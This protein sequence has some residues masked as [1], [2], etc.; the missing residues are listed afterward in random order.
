VNPSSGTVSVTNGSLVGTD[1]ISSTASLTSPAIVT[2]NVGNYSLTPSGVTFATGNASNYM[3]SYVN[4]TL[5]IMPRAITVKANNASRVYGDGNPASGA[6]SVIAGGLV[7]TDALGDANLLSAASAASSVGNYSL[8]PSGVKFTSGSAANYVIAYADGIL[9][10]TPRPL[11]VE[12]VGK[13]K[14]YDGTTSASVTF[15]DNRLD[16]DNFT[17]N[18]NAA[19]SDPDP[20]DNKTVSVTNINISGAD[21]GNYSLQN[22]F[23]FTTADIV[24]R[25]SALNKARSYLQPLFQPLMV[26]SAVKVSFMDTPNSDYYDWLLKNHL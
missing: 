24:T 4:G 14:L 25:E 3:I 5:T 6:V 23:A 16:G 1:A 11:S 15:K 21:A 20:G 17:V 9:T 19:F 12:A 2:S 7:G 8:T 22:T 18:G 10:I 26:L 13:N